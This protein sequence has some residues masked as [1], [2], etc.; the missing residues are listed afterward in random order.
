GHLG[1]KSLLVEA[2]DMLHVGSCKGDGAGKITGTF[3][4][5]MH[6]H[7]VPVG[8][9]YEQA[10]HQCMGQNFRVGVTAD[11]GQKSLA[12]GGRGTSAKHEGTHGG[13]SIR[14]RLE[15]S[16]TECKRSHRMTLLD[17]T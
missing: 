5:Q 8:L 3:Q 4:H 14:W 10:V 12:V 11:V 17:T 6:N 15:Y 9:R 1:Q 2:A 7:V 13:H 16:P